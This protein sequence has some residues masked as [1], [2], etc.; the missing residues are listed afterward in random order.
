[1]RERPTAGAGTHH[2]A[3]SPRSKADIGQ[4]GISGEDALLKEAILQLKSDISGEVFQVKSARDPSPRSRSPCGSGSAASRPRRIARIT[5]A[6]ITGARQVRD[7]PHDHIDA[8]STTSPLAARSS[9]FPR[10]R[11]RLAT[12]PPRSIH[13]GAGVIYM[14]FNQHGSKWI[15]S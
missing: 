10:G 4:V 7:P 8:W 2:W 3:C 5:I 9:S 13:R 11:D 6:R 1:M 12:A 14:N 15:T